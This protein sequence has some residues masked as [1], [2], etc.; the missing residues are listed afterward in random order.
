MTALA[1]LSIA[2][3]VYTYLG[4]PVLVT[5]LARLAPRRVRAASDYEP[6]VSI[7]MAVYNG[8]KFIAAKLASLMALDYPKEKIEILVCSDGSTDK[9]ARIVRELSRDDPRIRL[10]FTAARAGKPSALNLLTRAARNDVLVMCDVRQPLAPDALRGLL[11]ALSDPAVG[12]VSGNLML[13]GDTGASAYWTYEKLIRFSEARLG[14]LVGVSG[15][16]YAARRAEMP[17]LP[18]DVLLDDMF[19]PLSIARAGNKRIVF[20]E[21]AR[22]FDEACEDDREFQRKV[23]T[24]AGNY[25]LV[26]MMPWLLVP[27]RNPVWLQMM[28]HKLLR[29][30]CPWALVTLFIA[31]FALAFQP[32]LPTTS[33][34]FWRTLALAQLAFY[35]SALAGGR[36]GRLGSLART[37]TVLNAAAVAGLVR[38]VRNSQPV[39]W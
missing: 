36:A 15:S 24:L 33:L 14:S 35:A 11:P 37:F 26:R 3:I 31:S 17:T 23:R 38:F 19:V 20:S 10:V 5:A 12:C 13:A 27:R 1:L 16:L 4:Y 7:C 18:P 2:V 8:E 39:T 29:L 6:T 22:I 30:A 25:Q 32:D 21:E 34:L 28:S 9:T